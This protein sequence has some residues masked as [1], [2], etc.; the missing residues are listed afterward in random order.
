[1]LGFLLCSNPGS[2]WDSRRL[3]F[4][5]ALSIRFGVVTQEASSGKA[6]MTSNNDILRIV[7]NNFQ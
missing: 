3:T 2:V 6:N 4:S 7:M 5:N 1:M